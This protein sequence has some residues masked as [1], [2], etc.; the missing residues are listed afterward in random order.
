[1][2]GEVITVGDADFRREVLEADVAVLV[3]FTARWCPPCRAL[4]PVVEALASDYQGRLKVAKLD[5]D[6]NPV[7]AEQ[8]GI[9]AMPTLLLFH[10][11]K[12]VRQIVGAVPR[13]KLESAVQEFAR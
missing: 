4:A 3:D 2:A 9:R 1:M 10:R 11:G 8:Y 5:V 6:Y 13:A 7:V 12:V